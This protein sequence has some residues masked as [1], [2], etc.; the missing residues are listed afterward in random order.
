MRL[1]LISATIALV[2][3]WGFSMLQSSAPGTRAVV[4][5]SSLDGTSVSIVTDSASDPKLQVTASG[6]TRPL[7]GQT[8]RQ[9]DRIHFHPAL[10]FTPCQ[11]YIATWQSASGETQYASFEVAAAAA[12]RPTVKISPE[13]ALPA[14]ALR[15]YLHFSEP[16]EQGVF[17]DK[18]RLLDSAG[19]EISGPFRETELWSPDGKRLTVWFHPGRQKTGVNLQTDEGPVLTAD[20]RY[21][22]V[23][24]GDWRS[25]QGVSIGQEVLFPISTSGA[26]HTCPAVAKWKLTLPRSESLDPL[27]IDFD[28]PLDP[29]ILPGALSIKLAG[30][31]VQM[32]LTLLNSGKQWQ[33][34]PNQPWH[35]GD[36]ELH[37]SSILED[38]AGN[39]LLHPFEVDMEARATE[40]PPLIRTFTLEPVHEK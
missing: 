21:S 18:L 20:S 23:V 16:M 11:R 34:K 36:Y 35:T 24:S 14:N 40:S 2:T 19:R 1:V 12:P 5:E 28:E 25:V 31:Q 32:E 33:G 26:D 29:A 7:L 17:L 15:F 13:I 22:L 37:A 3:Y 27:I 6:L 4:I 38:L 39:N 9:E 8:E 30:V 10:P